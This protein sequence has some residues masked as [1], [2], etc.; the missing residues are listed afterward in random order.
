MLIASFSAFDT[1]GWRWP[2]FSPRELACRCG[3]K[4][5]KGEYWHE[6]AFLDALEALRAEIGA[7]LAI[8]SGHRCDLWNAWVG[9]AANSMHKQVAADVSLA[10]HDRHALKAAA[11]RTGFT[12]FGLGTNFLHIDRRAVPTVWLYPG[13]A[14]SW[15]T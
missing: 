1:A 7:P 9:G 3:G 14:K 5:C 10:G 2:H 11:Q 15:R 8:N 12:G 13:S 6:E 4:F